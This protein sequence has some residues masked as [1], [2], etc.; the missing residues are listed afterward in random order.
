MR[1]VV[2]LQ[3]PL[4]GVYSYLIMPVVGWTLMRIGPGGITLKVQ[5]ERGFQ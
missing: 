4:E 5:W 1:D 3:F 2:T